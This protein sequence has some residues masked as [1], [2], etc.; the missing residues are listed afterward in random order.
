MP[1][2]RSVFYTPSNNEK[3]VAKAPEIACDILTLDLEDSVAP[4][5]KAEAAI[6]VRN[7]LRAVNFYGAERMVR[8]RVYEYR[9]VDAPSCG[10]IS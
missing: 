6:L 7:T 2:M 4:A 10:A 8:T 9:H 3:M 1:V 5:K